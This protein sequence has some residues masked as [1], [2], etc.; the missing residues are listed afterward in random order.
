M[1]MN[2]KEHV[3][4][5]EVEEV[6]NTSGMTWKV[7][8]SL[9][10]ALTAIAYTGFFYGM[11]AINGFFLHNQLKFHPVVTF[12]YPIT[13]EPR[14]SGLISPEPLVIEAS[15][16]AS[17]DVIEETETTPEELGVKN[18]ITGEAS[19]YSVAGCIG[20]HPELIMANGDKLDDNELTLALPVDVVRQYRLMNQLIRVENA[21]NGQSVVAKVTDT[22][23][24]DKLG[25]VADLSVATKEALYCQD[26]CQ[27]NIYLP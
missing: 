14:Q 26:L 17:L 5:P 2:K 20:C 8:I 3:T 25:R 21:K 15:A 22:G 23:G 19:Y 4:E 11:V 24:F 10:L 16:S 6:N 9:A 12:N 1:N 27:V 7:R 13:I 18:V